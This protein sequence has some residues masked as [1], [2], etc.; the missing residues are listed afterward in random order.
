HGFLFM[1]SDLRGYYY[2]NTDWYK[3]AML[4]R[5]RKDYTADSKKAEK[6]FDFGEG[7]KYTA[8]NYKALEKEFA[9]T[10]LTK[11]EADFVAKID[12]KIAQLKQADYIE[13]DGRVYANAANVVNYFKYKN[14]SPEFL[15]KLSENNAVI[16]PEEKYEQLFYIYDKNNYAQIPSFITTDIMLQAFHMYFAYSI[17]ALEIEKFIPAL[18]KLAFTMHGKSMLAANSSEGDLKEAS[19]YNA[20]FYAVAYYLLTG[21]K[22]EIV[23]E[24]KSFFEDHIAKIEAQVDDGNIA[25]SQFKPRGYY[26]TS[27]KRSRYFKAMQWFQLMPYSSA[28]EDQFQ[29]AVVTAALLNSA[30]AETGETLLGLYK[31][32]LEPTTFLVGEPDNMSIMDIAS[33]LQ[34][35]KINDAAAALKQE[36]FAKIK[37]YLSD[38]AQTKGKIEAMDAGAINFMPARYLVDNDIMQNM[39]DM[40]NPGPRVFPKGLDVF[41]AF[42]SDTALD[43]LLNTY[44]EDKKWADY[45]PR[46]QKLRDRFKNYSDWNV[47]V[48]NK[49]IESL[50]ALQRAH[51]SYPAFM[52]LPAWDIKNLNTSLASWAELKHD[53]VLYAKQPIAAEGGEGGEDIPP[54]PDPYTVGYVEPNVQFWNKLDELLTLNKKMLSDN[55]VMTADLESKIN[56]LQEMV[57]FL[58]NVSKK[59]LKKENLTRE[60]YD[61]IKS[62][63]VW[64]EGFT[65]SVLSDPENSAGDME[66]RDNAWRDNSVAVVTDVFTRTASGVLHEGTG[67]ADTIYVIVEI[68]GNLYLTR[69]AVLSYY[70]FAMPANTRLT[71]EEWRKMLE[72]GKTPQKPVWTDKITLKSGGPQINEKIFYSMLYDSD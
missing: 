57:Q 71:D 13:K 2:V 59:E 33:F 37:K 46:M 16:V 21:N 12:S 44:E 31:S 3:K 56:R 60:E 45:M 40:D 15:Q 64:V 39:V 41:A 67:Y 24:Y 11:Q 61:K 14:L 23:Q 10:V 36:N 43:V 34:K 25:Y 50:L 65:Y 26:A 19:L 58:L 55:N 28:N 5:W 42:G 9:E 38:F 6:L 70:E 66:D 1:E 7:G 49:W 32:V 69:G 68:D 18:E 54:P 47:S 72:T 53:T 63:G 62:L 51:K 30:S 52:Q 48:Y 27:E 29:A 17:K 4:E 20:A 22:V 8:D 35:E